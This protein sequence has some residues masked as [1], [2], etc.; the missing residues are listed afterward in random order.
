[1]KN[2][3]TN[4]RKIAIWSDFFWCRLYQVKK[5]VAKRQDTC[6]RIVHLPNRMFVPTQKFLEEMVDAYFI[7]EF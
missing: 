2:T 7:E 3:R 4:V 1:M 5:E 6:F